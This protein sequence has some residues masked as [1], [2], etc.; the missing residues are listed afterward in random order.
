M[1]LA[2][3]RQQLPEPTGS[4][5]STG[6]QVAHVHVTDL[7]VAWISGVSD[8]TLNPKKKMETRPGKHSQFA[9]LKMAID[10]VDLPIKN[11]DFPYLCKR[12]PEHNTRQWPKGLVSFCPQ[13]VQTCPSLVV[14]INDHAVENKRLQLAKWIFHVGPWAFAGCVSSVEDVSACTFSQHLGSS[15]ELRHR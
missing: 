13:T 6:T 9:N 8:F 12:L 7:D 14:L 1:T 5:G 10:I 3:S 15:T 2:V 4:T 11:G